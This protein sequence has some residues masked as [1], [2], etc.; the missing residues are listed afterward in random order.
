MTPRLS[1]ILVLLT[2]ALAV[3]PSPAAA[4]SRK[5][6]VKAGTL[7]TDK[8]A[9]S[10]LWAANGTLYGCVKYGGEEPR[11]K[12][13]GP[14][15]AGGTVDFHD[16][17]AVW[18]TKIIRGG[19]RRD[20]V[21][22]ADAYTGKRF[23]AGKRLVP[24]TARTAESEARIQGVK[25]GPDAAA[26]VT[27]GGEV[28]AAIAHPDGAPFVEGEEVRAE[29]NRVLLGRFAAMPPELLA[30]L[31]ITESEGEG[32]ECG[33]SYDV[34]FSIPEGTVLTWGSEFAGPFPD[35]C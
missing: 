7:A 12:K 29:G 33:G 28:G 27:R 32:D 24:K 25:A 10:R 8:G 4:F 15:T 22:A 20:R 9:F 11:A 26:W 17:T 5:C 14:W 13:L 18:T 30:G 34:R 19:V 2:G 1:A 21:W 6:P 23:L 3:T 31:R 35:Y 16:T